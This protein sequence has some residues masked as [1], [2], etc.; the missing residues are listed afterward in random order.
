MG[1][2]LVLSTELMPKV[3]SKMTIKKYVKNQNGA[4]KQGEGGRHAMGACMAGV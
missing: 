3:N 4:K 1:A 2:A